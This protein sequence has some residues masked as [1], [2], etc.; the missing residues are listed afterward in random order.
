[1]AAVS[2]CAS[3]A[4]VPFKYDTNRFK[5]TL[6]QDGMWHL[7][8]KRIVPAPARVAAAPAPA[9]IAAPPIEA[10][11]TKTAIG[12]EPY[13]II[14]WTGLNGSSELGAGANLTFGITKNLT[15]VGFGEADNV[16]DEFIERFGGGLRYTA[17]LGKRVSLDATVAGGY[18][19]TDPHFF[20]RLQP[21]VNF[22]IYQSDSVDLGVRGAYGFDIDGNGKD[23]TA[24][25]RGFFGPVLNA[26]F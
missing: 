26:K 7:S 11:P 3:A 9:P 4:E 14:S 10:E 18:D 12:L 2:L 16:H 20:V 5:A 8:E 21:G 24:T 13:G 1:M 19:V 17:W 22:H 6:R 25:G 15:L 23:G